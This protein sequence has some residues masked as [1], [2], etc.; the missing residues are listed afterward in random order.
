MQKTGINGVAE[1]L[2][3]LGSKLRGSAAVVT[4]GVTLLACAPVY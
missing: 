4:A 3:R 2:R 1:R